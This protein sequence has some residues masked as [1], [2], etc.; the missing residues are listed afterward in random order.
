ML[1]GFSALTTLSLCLDFEI[2]SGDNPQP[3]YHHRI[4]WYRRCLNRRLAA[5]EA[6]AA[7]CPNLERCTWVQ[8][9]I[10]GRQSEY[11]HPF[12]VMKAKSGKHGTVRALVQWWMTKEWAS[13]L[14]G[15]LPKLA[16]EG[17]FWERWCEDALSVNF[18][19]GY[20]LS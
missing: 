10:M 9:G 18:Y 8:L 12:V 1:A 7:V 19:F 11:Y 3:A 5:T 16:R 6:I 13:K 4:E 15:P 14:L 20:K 2:Q 17:G